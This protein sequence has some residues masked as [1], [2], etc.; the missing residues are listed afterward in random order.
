MRGML[1]ASRSP[2]PRIT[3]P[4][5]VVASLERYFG[6]ARKAISAGPAESSVATPVSGAPTSPTASPPS[7]ATISRSVRAAKIDHLS[8]SALMTLSVM[9]IFPLANTASWRIRSNFSCSAI[10]LMTRVARSWTEAS[11]SLRRRLRSSRISR[12]MRWKLRLTSASWRSLSRRAASVIVTLSRSSSACMS[13]PCFSILASSAF[14]AANSF[15]SFCCARLAGEASRKTRSVFTNPIFR[16]AAAAGRT[17]PQ[18][19]NA[20]NHLFMSEP[21]ENLAELELEALD[22]VPGPLLHR[23]GEREA[24]GPDRRVPAYRDTDRDAHVLPA[25]E[26]V[27][28]PDVAAVD[29]ARQAHVLLLVA[30]HRKQHLEVAD[31][32]AVAAEDIAVLVLGSEA[33]HREA[34]DRSHAARVEVLEE[35]Q[36]LVLVAVRIAEL[37]VHHE[38]EE[39][40][41]LGSPEVLALVREAI[42]REV[43]RW[44]AHLEPDLVQPPMRGP[45]E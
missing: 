36:R 17:R 43:A 1:P 12:C 9:S 44:Q 16:S 39:G 2:G 14:L 24:Q 45:G 32:P 27:G 7:F 30:R 38:R 11:S 10:W 25:N 15:S 26:V 41:A 22:L 19:A 5:R 3:A 4:A 20:A 40:N 18:T 28:A 29:E 21:L 33:R 37:A 6:L 8:A 31:E 13:R 35:R 23:I 42:V 34:A